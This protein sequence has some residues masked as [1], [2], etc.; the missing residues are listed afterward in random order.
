M[1]KDEA[2]EGQSDEAMT[3]NENTEDAIF[4]PPPVHTTLVRE[5]RG[6]GFRLPWRG[7]AVAGL[8][9]AGASLAALAVVAGIS[10]ADSLAA[11]ALALATM[12]F[13]AQLI[14][15]LTQ[16][17]QLERQAENQRQV[18]A[19]TQ[20]A[21]V[22]VRASAVSVQRQMEGLVARLVDHALEVPPGVKD[23]AEAEAFQRAAEAIQKEV[24]RATGR[25]SPVQLIDGPRPWRA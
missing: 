17:I 12:S 15:V 19:D 22:E 8:V 14:I 16:F 4:G 21:L 2:I 10:D 11:V 6:D 23:A 1:P 3:L 25:Q 5:R 9:V 18:A 13:L 24:A 7:V 20:R